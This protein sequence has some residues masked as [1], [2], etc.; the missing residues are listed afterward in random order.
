MTP[1]EKARTFVYRSARPVDLA[2][3]RF[4]FE[5]GPAEDVMHA[6]SFYQNPD[7][8]L[9]HGL[10]ADSFNPNS[11]PIQTWCG[12]EIIREI[13]WQDP[14]HPVIRGILRYLDSGA[15]F[16]E[17]ERQWL[18]T[19]PS[20]S[21]YPCAVWW[22][23]SGQSEFRY[24]PTAALAGFGIRYADRYS[25]LYRKCAGIAEDAY[26]WFREN[27]PFEETHI[28]GCYLALYEYLTE[29]GAELIDTDEFRALLI[30]QANA[31][32]CR[33]PEQWRT[34]YVTLPSEYIASAD[35][36]LYPD[37]AELLTEEARLIPELLGTDGAFPVPWQWYNDDPG[38]P[39]AENWWKAHI[40]IRR[41]LPYRKICGGM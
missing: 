38:F 10:E 6:L 33:N 20:N 30:P 25:A 35:S 1:F 40:L 36:I 41:M 23:W 28:T 27:I 17:R 24:N 29:S 34:D 21:E 19:V 11:S 18:N 32:I 4:H 22:K 8:G 37:N 5:D 13:G 16:D 14:S 12:T 7:G 39:L 15:D 3:W 2:R 31:N 9:G 26:R